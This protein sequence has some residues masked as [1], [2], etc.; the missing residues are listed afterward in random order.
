MASYAGVTDRRLEAVARSLVDKLLQRGGALP[1]VIGRF[2]RMH[3]GGGR[4]LDNATLLKAL[5]G[6]LPGTKDDE[7]AALA[8]RFD[9]DGSGAVSVAELTRALQA[10]AEGGEP[11]RAPSEI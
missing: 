9:Q 4:E 6:A 11:K 1:V 8:D 3:A 2:L 10:R 7:L 5:A